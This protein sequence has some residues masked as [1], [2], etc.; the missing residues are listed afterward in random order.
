MSGHVTV[1]RA[2]QAAVGVRVVRGWS[3]RWKL[4]LGVYR[5]RRRLAVLHASTLGD[6]LGVP[7]LGKVESVLCALDIDAE[8]ET[9]LTHVP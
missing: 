5:R 6:V 3:V 7:V 1:E 8:E 4:A 2:R 9:E